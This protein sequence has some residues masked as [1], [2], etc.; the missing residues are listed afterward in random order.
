MN[1]TLKI[2]L[3]TFFCC[4]NSVHADYAHPSEVPILQ[5]GL[6]NFFEGAQTKEKYIESHL[7][8]FEIFNSPDFFNEDTLENIE[9]IYKSYS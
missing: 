3:V 5:R 9:A 6:V 7:Q 1:K 2:F 4:S 8:V